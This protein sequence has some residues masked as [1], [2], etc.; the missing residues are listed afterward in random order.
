M[1]KTILVDDKT[2][3]I[4]VLTKMLTEYCPRLTITGTAQNTFDAIKLILR[5]QPDLLFLDI[6]I[7]NESGFDLLE[8]VKGSYKEVIF[9][10]AYEQ[11]AIK[12]IREQAIDYLLKPVEI[13]ALIQAVRKA[14]EQIRLKEINDGGRRI[15]N[16]SRAHRISLPTPDGLIFV[17]PHEVVC[18]N[19]SGSYTYFFLQNGQKILVSMNLGQCEDLLPDFDFFRVHAAHLVNINFIAR[20]VRGRGGHLVLQDGTVVKVAVNRKSDFLRLFN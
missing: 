16:E 4:N 3:N 2:G 6:E 10:T 19:A 14:E 5:Y 9:V 20:Y 12:A 13:T 15:P 8:K 7:N 11:Y 18:C 1:L 17:D